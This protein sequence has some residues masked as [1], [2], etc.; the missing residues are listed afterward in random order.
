[1]QAILRRCALAATLAAG[2]VAPQANATAAGTAVATTY[3]V[4]HS[5]SRAG[6][7]GAVVSNIAVL[8][9]VSRN[10]AATPNGGNNGA[11]T[12]NARRAES[13]LPS[14]AA[15]AAAASTR[16]VASVH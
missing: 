9:E 11:N 1:M 8:D 12:R 14:A 3:A 5:S 4:R 2:A 13:F 7:Y 10:V 15:S 6:E 16:V